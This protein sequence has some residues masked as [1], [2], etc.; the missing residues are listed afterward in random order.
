MTG[1]TSAPQ[2][3]A[4]LDA[5]D[6]IAPVDIKIKLDGGASYDLPD[7]HTIDAGPTG[8]PVGDCAGANAPRGTAARRPVDHLVAGQCPT[9]IAMKNRSG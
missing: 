5:L 9:L 3:Y 8:G 6:L 2:M 7:F 1:W 4:A